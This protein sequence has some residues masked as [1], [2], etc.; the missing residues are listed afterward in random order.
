MR[1]L[2]ALAVLL[3]VVGAWLGRSAVGA[4]RSGRKH[5]VV[6]QVST[7]DPK[8]WDVTLN[9]V[10]NIIAGAGADNVDIQVV[11]FGPG[12]GIFKK[13]NAEIAE[14]LAKYKEI[15]P[16]GLR[17]NS[18]AVTMKKTGVKQEDLS[19]VVETTASGVLRIIEL[20]EQGYTYIR[21]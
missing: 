5:K 16:L 13:N 6:I 2:A 11:A 7:D 17:L 14:R 8:T 3:A 4:I 10:Y 21:P 9:N 15:C 19:P 18:C 1:R 20:Q 12:L